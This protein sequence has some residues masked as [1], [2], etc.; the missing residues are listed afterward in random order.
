MIKPLVTGLIGFGNIGSG[1][2]RAMAERAEELKARLPRPIV[3]KSI[4]DKDT[5][6]RRDAPYHKDQLHGDAAVVLED[7]EIEAVMELIGGVEPART[8]VERALRAGKHVV[9]ANKALLAT[10]GPELL[11]LAAENG[12]GL[13]YEGAVG[14][15]IPII[16]TLQQGLSANRLTAVRGI[17]NGTCNY[18]LTRMAE[19]GLPFDQALTEAQEFGYAEP[20]PTYDIEGYDTAH[21]I[22]ILAS[23]AFG[24]DIRFDDVFVHGITDIHPVDI[25]HARELG[26]AIKLL[27]IA[28]RHASDGSVIV[29]VHPTLVPLASPLGMVGGVFNSILVEG[30]PIGPTV[31]YGRGAGPEATSSAILSDLMALASDTHGFNAARDAR[32]TVRVGE[33]TLRPIDQL[34][35]NYYIRFSMV[36][37][38]GAMAEIGRALAE[39]NVSIESMIQHRVELAQG[40][41]TITI[42]THEALEKDV[43]GAIAAVEA[44]EKSAGKAFVLR[45]EE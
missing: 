23:L 31:Y 4:A 8:F 29:R 43:Q 25:K 3:L 18:I 36:D 20:D 10:H 44:S 40:M 35:T 39:H 2:L 45:V 26:Y 1:V 42:V 22:A 41:A 15:G 37:R 5:T 30:T 11:A 14:G 9:T 16:R 13:L 7:P 12:V 38:P 19:A 6:T 24:M 21:K 27:G 34:R 32:L 17:L 33:R 28:Q